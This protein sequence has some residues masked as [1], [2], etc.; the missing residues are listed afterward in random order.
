MIEAALERAAWAQASRD[1]VAGLGQKAT[2]TG[3]SLAPI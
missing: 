3:A 2:I 1:F